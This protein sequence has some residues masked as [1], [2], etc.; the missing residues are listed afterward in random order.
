MAP[1]RHLEG[2]SMAVSKRYIGDAVYAD[3]EGGMI[4]LTTEDG[5]AATNTIYL[6]MEVWHALVRFVS[7]VFADAKAAD[8]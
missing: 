4:V 2:R 3:V 8:L 7:D 6:E 1:A 5:I